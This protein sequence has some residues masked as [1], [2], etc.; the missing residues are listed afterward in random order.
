M[1]VSGLDRLIA[2]TT[3]L[4][5]KFFPLRGPWFLDTILA[6]RGLCPRGLRETQNLQIEINPEANVDSGL[7]NWLPEGHILPFGSNHLTQV[8]GLA[9]H[10]LTVDAKSSIAWAH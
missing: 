10:Q 6:F 2:P 3:D 8:A 5:G 4:A 1:A 7:S 9:E